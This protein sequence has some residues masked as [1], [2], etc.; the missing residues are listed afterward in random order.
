MFSGSA[1]TRNVFVLALVVVCAK[2]TFAQT[3]KTP[4][5]IATGQCRPDLAL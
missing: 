2:L 1:Q 5:K 3:T 4:M